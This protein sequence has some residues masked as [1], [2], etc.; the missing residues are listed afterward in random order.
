MTDSQIPDMLLA[1]APLAVA[2]DD[3]AEVRAYFRE[4]LFIVQRRDGSTV[5]L[6]RYDYYRL[7]A[8]LG[9]AATLRPCREVTGW[10]D[11]VWKMLDVRQ[12]APAEEGE[13]P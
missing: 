12:A 5:A 8:G 2:L 6:S 3:V 1:D 10:Y 13:E 7:L 9:A 4:E 11:A